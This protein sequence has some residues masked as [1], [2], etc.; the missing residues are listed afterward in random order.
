MKEYS[1]NK[2]TRW[3]ESENKWN[4]Y[5]KKITSE[6]PAWARTLNYT[7]LSHGYNKLPVDD[8]K[9]VC[10]LSYMDIER[11]LKQR[12][13]INTLSKCWAKYNDCFIG[14]IEN[15]LKK[16]IEKEKEAIE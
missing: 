12:E 4:E 5:W 9:V 11:G 10:R 15:L 6:Q 7:I 1:V 8:R 16:I 2:K 14:N 13:S 3:F